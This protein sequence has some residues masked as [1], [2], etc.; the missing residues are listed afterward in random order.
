[1]NAILNDDIGKLI[2]RLTTGI[3]MLFHGVAKI[4]HTDSLTFIFS[5]A[6]GF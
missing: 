2:L 4:L 6:Y 5:T 3:L 1:M